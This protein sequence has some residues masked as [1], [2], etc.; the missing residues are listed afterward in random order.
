MAT[1]TLTVGAV[2]LADRLARFW[3]RETERECW[4]VHTQRDLKEAS[5]VRE[6]S[7]YRQFG[8]VRLV[9][10]AAIRAWW[11]AMHLCM[12]VTG[13]FWAGGRR[14]TQQRGLRRTFA[15]FLDAF[16]LDHQTKT[17]PKN[18]RNTCR[19]YAHR[20]E[21]H[22]VLYTDTPKRITN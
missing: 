14:L 19:R 13:T 8:T 7:M 2:R 11:H 16:V 6:D 20:V 1:A 17:S 12:T 4:L 10:S 5:Y 9:A 3:Q 18:T 15:C 21:K 22:E